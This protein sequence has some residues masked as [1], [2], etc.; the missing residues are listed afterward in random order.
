MG[1]E[2]TTGYAE[3][4]CFQ[5]SE[6]VPSPLKGETC[7]PLSFITHV[8]RLMLSSAHYLLLKIQ[9]RHY[10]KVC[11]VF[12]LPQV[13]NLSKVEGLHLSESVRGGRK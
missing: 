5:A 10:L 7:N 8:K 9:G 11:L 3:C 2:S 6:E 4:L 13:I 12:S 1:F